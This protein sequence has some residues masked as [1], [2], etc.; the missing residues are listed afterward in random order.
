MTV[1]NFDAKAR[2]F[3]HVFKASSNKK[4]RKADPAKVGHHFVTQKLGGVKGIIRRGLKKTLKRDTTHYQNQYLDFLKAR[5][6]SIK[7]T[8]LQRFGFKRPIPRGKHP[9]ASLKGNKK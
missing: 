2:K 8:K 6:E 4:I 5:S 3:K 9:P 7:Q 1:K